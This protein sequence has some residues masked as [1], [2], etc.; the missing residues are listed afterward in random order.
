MLEIIGE[1]GS[2][3]ATQLNNVDINKFKHSNTTQ[4]CTCHAPNMIDYSI[5]YKKHYFRALLLL[6]Y[7]LRRSVNSHR[8]RL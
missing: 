6:L 2:E 7:R 1:V 3:G 4:E 8:G 5:N